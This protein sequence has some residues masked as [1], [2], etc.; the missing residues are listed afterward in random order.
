MNFKLFGLVLMST[1]TAVL[2]FYVSNNHYNEH[3]FEEM[4][5]MNEMMA[6]EGASTGLAQGLQPLQQL[7]QQLEKEKL[8][9]KKNQLNQKEKGMFNA[10]GGP[11]RQ[12]KGKEKKKFKNQQPLQKMEFDHEDDL[13]LLNFLAQQ[14]NQEIKPQFKVSQSSEDSSK[15]KERITALKK[16]EK[17]FKQLKR[18]QRRIRRRIRRNQRRSR[19]RNN[20]NRRK[21][22]V[23]RK[24]NEQDLSPDL[25]AM[26]QLQK[27]QAM[28][29]IKFSNIPKRNPKSADPKKD[30]WYNNMDLSGVKNVATITVAFGVIVAVL[31]CV[32]FQL[33]RMFKSPK[34]KGG[35]KESAADLIARR[36]TYTY[37]RIA[38]DMDAEDTI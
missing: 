9:K 8:N 36:S 10:N 24:T 11:I 37:D 23:N 28:K 15:L 30:S 13:V 21:R 32:L 6:L 2:A 7:I 5:L 17:R 16:A 26:K 14:E 31:F 22:T 3:E 35:S 1:S 18:E 38:L 19:R 12:G 34:G 20:R 33:F 25:L 4:M 27:Q 29:P